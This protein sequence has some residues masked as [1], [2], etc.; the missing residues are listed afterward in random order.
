M[1]TTTKT[2]ATDQTLEK[3]R[4]TLSKQSSDQ[5]IGKLEKDTL[6]NSSKDIAIEILKKRNVDVARFEGKAT[7]KATKA[8]VAPGKKKLDIDDQATGKRKKTKKDDDGDLDLSNTRIFDEEGAGVDD[9]DDDT[10]EIPKV[11]KITADKKATKK[12]KEEKPVKEKKEKS[13]KEKKE[14]VARAS[15][16]DEKTI[17]EIK[18]LHKEGKS[19]YAIRVELELSWSSVNKVING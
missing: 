2:T 17:A 14:R 12:E 13:V 9:D 10:L 5:L 8:S 16:L 3:L 11:Q 15:T 19:L 6:F 7:A 18:K 4:A 1:T